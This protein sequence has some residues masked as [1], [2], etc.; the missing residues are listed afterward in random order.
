MT[1][2]PRTSLFGISTT[3]TTATRP[4]NP[5]HGT[6]G[7]NETTQEI[8]VYNAVGGY[9]MTTTDLTEIYP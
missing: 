8:E 5:N 9:W 4:T 6:T 7:F 1:Y 2:V 3:W